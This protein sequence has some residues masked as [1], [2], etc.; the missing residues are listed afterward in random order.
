MNVLLQF[1]GVCREIV[2]NN[3]IAV[4]VVSCLEW[5]SEAA[6]KQTVSRPRSKPGEFLILKKSTN[7]SP[8]A[9]CYIYSGF[10]YVVLLL[11]VSDSD[12]ECHTF[13]EYRT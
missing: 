8:T 5:L 13:G 2:E 10:E 4:C 11:Q 3:V 1:L 6:K 7:H 9:L 12:T